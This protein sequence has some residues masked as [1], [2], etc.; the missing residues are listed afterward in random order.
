M[1]AQGIPTDCLD[2]GTTAVGELGRVDPRLLRDAEVVVLPDGIDRLLNLC[3]YLAVEVVI[4]IAW[5]V[6][7]RVGR[8]RDTNDAGYLFSFQK[9]AEA[10]TS[11]GGW[12]KAKELHLMVA[13]LLEFENML[14]GRDEFLVDVLAEHIR[15]VWWSGSGTVAAH[16]SNARSEKTVHGLSD[17]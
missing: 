12:D 2:F 13:E 16:L 6:L 7:M 10:P 4:Q 15:S 17:W 11:P 14:R 8:S 3:S 1:F 9:R 5:L